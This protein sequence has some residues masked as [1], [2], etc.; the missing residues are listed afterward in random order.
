MTKQRKKDIAFPRYQQ[1]AVAVAQRIVDG[2][3]PVGSKIYARSTLASNFNVSSE[4]ARKAINILVD[5]GIMEV[6]HGSGAYISSKEKARKFLETSQ[7]AHSLQDLKQK[8]QESIRH[9]EEEFANFSKLLNQLLTRTKDI[10]NRSPFD[11]FELTLTETAQN[12]DRSIS[13][14]NIWHSTGATILAVQHHNELL[15]SPGPYTRLYSGDVIYFVG[16]ELSVGLM[17]NLFYSSAS[18]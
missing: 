16:N 8:L 12:L 15:V 13:E 3:Y 9:Q 18:H 7:D 17:Q 6:R 2:K 5:L 14:L 10:Q 4:T 1:I 11:P